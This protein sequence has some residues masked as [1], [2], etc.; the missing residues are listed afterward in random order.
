MNSAVKMPKTQKFVR[1]LGSFTRVVVTKLGANDMGNHVTF[2]FAG[3]PRN[4]V[5]TLIQNIGKCRT[6]VGGAPH[7][8]CQ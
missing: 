4:P 3:E 2:S 8:S 1:R 5:M 7:S 6:V